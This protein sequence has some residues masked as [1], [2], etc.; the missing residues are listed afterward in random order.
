MKKAKPSSPQA[1]PVRVVVVDDN[2]DIRY[3][4]SSILSFDGVAHAS[5][6][7]FG[8]ALQQV[9]LHDPA[10]CICDIFMPRQ[11]GLQL[12]AA[13]RGKGYTGKILAISGGGFYRSFSVLQAARI[14]GADAS[15][16]KPFEVNQLRRVV[17]DLLDERAA[18]IRA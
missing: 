1:A 7:S 17:G 14:L 4:I 9:A 15:L 5:A 11:G 16:R 2:D 18:Q 13:L 6:E 3:T 12:I 8:A 10:L